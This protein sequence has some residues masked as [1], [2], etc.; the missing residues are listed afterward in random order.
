[1][2]KLIKVILCGVLTSIALLSLGCSLLD[3]EELSI[4]KYADE[5]R[6]LKLANEQ[7]FSNRATIYGTSPAFA[8]DWTDIPDFKIIDIYNFNLVSGTRTI[9]HD[10]EPTT[11]STLFEEKVT[12]NIT[13]AV[14][15]THLN[16]NI[17]VTADSSVVNGEKTVTIVSGDIKVDY[18]YAPRTELA[19][20]SL[21]Y[22]GINQQQTVV[23]A[24]GTRS[25]VA[26]FFSYPGTFVYD[27]VA[28]VINLEGPTSSEGKLSIA[29]A[30]QLEGISVG[31][32]TLT[33]DSYDQWLEGAPLVQIQD[34]AG[35]YIAD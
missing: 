15:T 24:S 11:A 31:S 19:P 28:F 5:L 17:T 32:V 10:A 34:V 23:A 9:K 14:F 29:G 21:T 22:S 26:T 13:Q 6:A 30:V 7:I 20:F 8:E 1:M 18:T 12:V 33:W 35:N 4:P 3:S 25:S 27:S 16:H 2:K